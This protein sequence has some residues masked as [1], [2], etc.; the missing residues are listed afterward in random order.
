MRLVIYSD[1][2]FYAGCEHLITNICNSKLIQEQFEIQFAFRN[3]RIYRQAVELRIP[4][5][6]RRSPLPI[7]SFDGLFYKLSFFRTH[8]ILKFFLKAILYIAQSLNIHTL[9]NILVLSIF[10][11]RTKADVVHVNNGGY[12]AARSALLAV[13][14][15]RKLVCKK[16]ILSVNNMAFAP[17]TWL[18]RLID[19]HVA[20]A[21]SFFHTASKA[22]GQH[23]AAT[24]NF[25]SN[26]L[27]PIPNTFQIK[28]IPRADIRSLI[29]ISKETKIVGSAGLLTQRKGFHVLVEAF[30]NLVLQD[31]QSH[32]VILG[33][34]EE[35][36]N[37]EKLI[38][39]HN[40]TNHVHLLGHKP[41]VLEFIQDF[42][43]F[44]LPSISNEDFPYVVIEAMSLAKP[45]IGTHVAGIPEQLDGGAGWVVPPN[46]ALEL[47]KAIGKILLNAGDRA[48][49][50]E[51]A[52]KKYNECYSY[53]KV[54]YRFL[55]LY[56]SPQN[57]DLK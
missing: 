53:E 17:K 35:R 52:Q 12:P 14:I 44:V 55:E 24:R 11:S 7:A 25:D 28:A 15:A 50:G 34:G 6:V 31:P 9:W 45:I 29:N 41:N 49:L 30:K 54:T 37:L 23:L 13:I 2:I 27:R 22:A 10:F 47:E 3:H 40:L 51:R 18:E 5:V 56:L 43:V 20:K 42:D 16:I 48:E 33:E 57:V 21:V 32:L 8:R 46:D 26:K 1:C 19:K 38:S 39:T 36:T 4:S